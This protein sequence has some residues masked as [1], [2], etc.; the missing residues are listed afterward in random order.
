[1]K[2]IFTDQYANIFMLLNGLVILFYLGAWKKNKQRAMKF[3]NYKTLQKVAGKNFLKS[4]NVV[5]VV[6]MLALTALI[7]GISS[8]VLVEQTPSSSSDYV[9]AIDSSTSMLANDLDPSRFEAAKDISSDFVNRLSP[10]TRVGVTSFS[11]E[12]IKDSE[13]TSD[14]SEVTEKIKQINIGGKAGTA[15]GDALSTSSAMLIGQN[16]S[17][18]IILITDGRNNVGGSINDS[19]IFAKR[20]N[21]TVHTIGIGSKQNSSSNYGIVNGQ[22]ASRAV[23]PNLN[24]AS[25]QRVSNETGGQFNTVTNKSSLRSAFITLEKTRREQDLSTP[26]IFLAAF[27][28]LLEWVIGT[29]RYSVIP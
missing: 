26:F 17:K 5:L 25:L 19:L 18:S 15:I 20:H 28:L 4:S 29:T 12:V 16:K 8:P 3:G 10:E 23:F 14:K 27:F 9:I 1:V 24:Q 2:L 6:R 13:L 22:N 21:V 11:G 7:I